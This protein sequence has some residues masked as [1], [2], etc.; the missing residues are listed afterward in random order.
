LNFRISLI[1]V[2]VVEFYDQVIFHF[3]NAGD[4]LGVS[5]GHLVDVGPCIRGN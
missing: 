4:T 5:V 2:M 1:R 3:I